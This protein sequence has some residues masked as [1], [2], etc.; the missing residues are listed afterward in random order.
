MRRRTH[1]QA[2]FSPLQDKTL[3]NVLR[4]LFVT[5]FGYQN[6]VLF[7]EAM[8]DRILETVESFVQP[9]ALLKPGQLLWMAVVNDGRKHAHQPMREI[10]QVPVILDLVTDGELGALA[11]GKDWRVVRRRRHARLLE[12]AFAQGGVLAQSDLA[13]LTLTSTTT[14]RADI[15]HFRETENRLLPYRGSVQ[16]VGGTLTHKVEAIRLFEAGYLEPEICR[17]LPILHDLPAVENYVQTY[18]NVIKLLERG[19]APGEV[20]GILTIDKRLVQAYVD[21]IHEHR[22]KILAANPHFQQ[23]AIPCGARPSYGSEVPK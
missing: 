19:F 7:A 3:T 18:K 4:Q 6:K 16:D 8:I 15:S 5:E 1:R 21:I 12:Q 14:V 10:P 9:A 17:K 2:D 22:P 23:Q 20:S 11:S 13:A